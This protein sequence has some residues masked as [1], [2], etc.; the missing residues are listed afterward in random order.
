MARTTGNS[1]RRISMHYGDLSHLALLGESG[2][3][4]TFGLNLL[5]I[6]CVARYPNAGVA[7]FDRRRPGA[8]VGMRLGQRRS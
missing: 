3:G 6:Q 2:G 1:L 7:R 5:D 8:N 4:K